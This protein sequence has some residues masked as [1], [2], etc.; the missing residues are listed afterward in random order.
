[1]R[2][3]SAFIS[4]LPTTLPSPSGICLS[5]AELSSICEVEMSRQYC[6]SKWGRGYAREVA[7]LP[8]P[9][10]LPPPKSWGSAKD[11]AKRGGRE[12]GSE[13][14]P[15]PSSAGFAGTLVC[16]VCNEFQLGF[17]RQGAR[18]TG[19]APMRFARCRNG[20]VTDTSSYL[21]WT[22]LRCKHPAKKS[23]IHAFIGETQPECFSGIAA[24]LKVMEK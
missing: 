10:L 23:Y 21:S 6:R 11:L 5:V 2:L 9:P 22:C 20:T 18:G 14:E 1:M 15:P 7:A 8:S 16:L 24:K 4:S 12:K 13:G 3:F 19:R 17:S